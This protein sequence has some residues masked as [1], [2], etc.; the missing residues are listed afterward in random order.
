MGVP[1]AD[2][3]AGIAVH[4][5]DD[6]EIQRLNLQHM[7]EDRPTDVLSFPARSADGPPAFD[8]PRRPDLERRGQ[9]PQRSASATS[10]SAGTPSA[11]RPARPPALDEATVLAIHGLAH[12][13]GHD[14]AG[15]RDGRAMHRRERRGL[16]AARVADIP[17]PY[18]LRPRRPLMRRVRPAMLRR[19]RPVLVV[20]GGSGTVSPE[21]HDAAVAGT[22]EAA[23]AG[24]ARSCWPAAPART[25]PSPRSACSRMTPPSTPAAAPA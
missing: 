15:R 10:S 19:M 16:S 9:G 11:A 21:H 7:G 4:I 8:R 14:H 12:L 13:L 1:A 5:V 2:E 17:R 18:G 3:L 23:R 20:H 6:A 25:R 22:R 24:Q